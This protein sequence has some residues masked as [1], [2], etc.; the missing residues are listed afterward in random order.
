MNGYGGDG[1]DF[2]SLTVGATDQPADQ[3]GSVGAATLTVGS[4]TNVNVD[5]QLR[6]ADFTAGGNTI[7]VGNVKYNDTDTTVGAGTL[8]TSYVTWYSVNANT[9]DVTQCYHWIS[10]PG[11][12]AA[13]D[14]TSTFYYQA[15]Q[16]P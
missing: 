16:Q 3:T 13:G 4:E 10:I 15:V 1:I 9:A 8:T 7:A 6:G 5:V 11:G 2:G 12:Q 14:C